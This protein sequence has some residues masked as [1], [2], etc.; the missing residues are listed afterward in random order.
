MA[1]Q[2]FVSVRNLQ[3]KYG[4]TTAVHELDLEVKEGELCVLLGPSGCGKTTTMRCI[5]GLETPVR[6]EISIG[7]RQ[8]FSANRKLFVSPNKRDVGMV[9]QSYA[10]WP[11]RTVFE[12][13]AFPLQMKK[14]AKA[15]I[16]EQVES[17][18]DLVGLAGM[19]NRGATALS[20]GQMQRVALARSLVTR[21]Q[22]LLMDEPLSNLDAKLRDQLR[23]ELKALQI[24]LGLTSIYVTHDQGEAFALADQVIVMRDGQIVQKGTPQ[25]IY[26]KPTS[27]F[28][29]DFLGMTNIFPAEV[30]SQE[31]G[32][33]TVALQGGTEITLQGQDVPSRGLSVAIPAESLTFGS[34]DNSVNAL[35][36]VVI[37]RSFLG[38][39]WRFRVETGTGL[40]IDVVTS[41]AVRVP[42]VGDV[43]T[44]SVDESSINLLPSD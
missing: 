40:T 30:V 1:A 15:T 13:V 42:K 10:I 22:V 5:A 9:F 18:L 35:S 26:R 27:R 34:E 21:P 16:K 29:A 3:V 33:V 11:H 41:D 36:G 44:L 23:F 2:P 39:I 28:V 8:V 19:G 24:Q 6:G 17:A 7:G 20:G 37:V 32:R 25:E 14:A 4:D 12:N 43:I 31:R 38:A